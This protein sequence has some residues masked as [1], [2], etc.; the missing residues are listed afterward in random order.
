MARAYARYARD[1]DDLVAWLAQQM[2]QAQLTKLMRIGWET[3]GKIHARVVAEKLPAGRLDALQLLG[4][5]D[6]SY[7][8]DHKFLTCVANHE[9]GGIVW[10]PRVATAPA[11]RHSSTGSPTLRRSRS[12]R[13]R[14]TCQPDMRT[15]SA[16]RSPTPRSAST[17][18]GGK[19][20]DQVRRDEYNRHGRSSTGEGKWMVR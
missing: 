8:T 9:T 15:R 14:S 20:A 7:G 11:C 4:V 16:P 12:G 17:R 6:V 1:L 18:F 19:A 2:N 10:P 5:D 3:I 13:F